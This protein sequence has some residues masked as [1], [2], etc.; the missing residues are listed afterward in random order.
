MAL[1]PV[2]RCG[3]DAVPGEDAGAGGPLG[4][5]HQ[6][7][8]LAGRLVEAGPSAR[9]LDAPD[10]RDRWKGHGQGRDQARL[11]RRRGRRREL[12]AGAVR[13]LQGGAFQ[14][15]GQGIQRPLERLPDSLADGLADQ[16]RRLD[17][18]AE[19]LGG[20]PPAHGRALGRPGHGLAP[21]RSAAAGAPD[22]AGAC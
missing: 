17:R 3:A 16:L 22:A 4:E 12:P 9:Q 5:P 13:A 21:W 18:G 10:R 6:Q 14:H 15:A 7:H 19:R 8:I 11:L 2:D 20:G 1:A